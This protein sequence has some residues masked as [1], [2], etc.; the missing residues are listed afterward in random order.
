MKL[1][2]AWK[3]QV[4]FARPYASW[5]RGLNEHTNGLVRQYFP[6]GTDLTGISAKN[7]QKIEDLLN[8]RPRKVLDYRTPAEIFLA[9]VT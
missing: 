1:Q 7:L 3:T 5:Q 4:F 6:K 9:T 8:N 2:S